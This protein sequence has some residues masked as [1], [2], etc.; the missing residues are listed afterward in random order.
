MTGERRH[1]PE[2]ARDK[3]DSALNETRG[4]EG[5]KVAQETP[6]EEEEEEEDEEEDD[7]EKD[8]EAKERLSH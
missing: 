2:R 3:E 5:E 8:G 6:K 4:R 7:D 1:R